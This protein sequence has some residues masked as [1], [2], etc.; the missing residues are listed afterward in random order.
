MS[1]WANFFLLTTTSSVVL[2]SRRANFR[3]SPFWLPICFVHSPFIPN[4]FVI[5]FLSFFIIKI[6]LFSQHKKNK[7]P[8]N[9]QKVQ[10]NSSHSTHN[11][12]QFP[13]LNICQKSSQH[14][15]ILCHLNTSKN[16]IFPTPPHSKIATNANN[17]TSTAI[18][19]P[20]WRQ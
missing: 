12:G 14:C 13:V 16:W 18:F 17:A 5:I 10:K 15:A 3:D 1:Q 19:I 20:G 9:L 6:F 11:S 7:I 4:F 2:L 8:C